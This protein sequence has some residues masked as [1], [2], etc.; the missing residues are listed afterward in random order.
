MEV[1]EQ[2]K[3]RWNEIYSALCGKRA[4]LCQIKRYGWM[5]RFWS[6][7]SLTPNS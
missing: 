3:R 4:Q 2:G 1:T 6:P 7:E 5:P